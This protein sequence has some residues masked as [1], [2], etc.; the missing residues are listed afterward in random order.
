MASS[1]VENVPGESKQMCQAVGLA[2]RAFSSLSSCQSDARDKV[3]EWETGKLALQWASKR[4]NLSGI[5]RPNFASQTS[6]EQL[7]NEIQGS[8]HAKCE[9]PDVMKNAVLQRNAV[10]EQPLEEH[11]LPKQQS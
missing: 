8:Q 3:M 1:E 5:L 2:H 7:P 10:S 4:L 11:I 9:H 6:R